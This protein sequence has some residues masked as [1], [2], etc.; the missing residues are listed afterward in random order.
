MPNAA[1]RMLIIQSKD[2]ASLLANVW[3]TLHVV[4]H[5]KGLCFDFMLS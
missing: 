2:F 4:D 1:Q 3:V 5:Y